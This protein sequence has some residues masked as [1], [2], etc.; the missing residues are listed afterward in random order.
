MAVRLVGGGAAGLQFVWLVR[1][2]LPLFLNFI[3]IKFA[4]EPVN[5]FALFLLTQGRGRLNK[6]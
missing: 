3:S 4:Y 1:N 6:F 5:R 2:R